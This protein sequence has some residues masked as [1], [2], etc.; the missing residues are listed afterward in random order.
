MP[1]LTFFQKINPVSYIKEKE[2]TNE[3]KLKIS[4]LEEKISEF[5]KMEQFLKENSVLNKKFIL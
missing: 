1:Y 4:S 3:L 5:E 2:E